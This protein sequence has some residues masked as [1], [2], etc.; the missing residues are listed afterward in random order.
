MAGIERIP[1]RYPS[2]APAWFVRFMGEFV[3][4]VLAPADARNAVSGSGISIEGTPDRPVTI[5]S[6]SNVLEFVDANFVLAESSADLG[7]SRVLRGEGDVVAITDGGPGQSITVGLVQHGVTMDKIQVLPITTLL[8]NPFGSLN[9]PV[10]ITAY[11]DDTILQRTA[12]SLEF[13]PL[14]L[15]MAADGLWT[16]AKMQAISATSRLLGRVSAGAGVMEEL[17]GAEVTGLLDAF[18]ASLQGVVPASGGGAVN[19][20]RADGTWAAPDAIKVTS[21][22][23]SDTITPDADTRIIRPAALAAALTIANPA[24]AP[25]DGWTMDVELVDDGTSRALTWGAAY[26][27]DVATL[28][29]ATTAAKRHYVTLRYSAAATV[30]RCLSALVQA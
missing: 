7:N 1:I 19:F 16:Y 8:G 11:D 26:A 5:S 30:F 27:S 12:G 21:A 6:A 24:T 20:L 13:A 25:A 29:A 18:S 14:T 4:D 28:P 3:R 23:T 22:V 15:N 9:A 2:E 10:A 17:T